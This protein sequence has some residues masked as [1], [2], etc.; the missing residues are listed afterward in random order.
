MRLRIRHATRYTYDRP[1]DYA[2]Q[3]VR[4]TPLNHMGQRVLS[5]R[6]VE[7]PGRRLPVTDDGYGNIVHMLTL[8]RQH[9]EATVLAEGEVETFD[10][11]GILK[12]SVERLPPLYYLRGTDMTEPDEALEALAEEVAAT[13]DPVKRLHRLMLATRARVAYQVGATTVTTT[14]VE[15]FA[16][17]SGVCQDH[18]HI[19]IACA[20]LLG[21]PA[22][23]VSGYLWEGPKEGPSEASHAWAEAHLGELGWVGFDPANGISPTEAYVRVAIG[24]D[25][26]EAAPIRG[27]RRGAAEESLAVS[28]GV[29]QVQA[30]Q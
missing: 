3:L 15:A 25:Y 9:R 1:I 6:V 11:N 20:R 18:A 24:L 29:E 28:V 4:L 10:T 23:Y 14:A 13:A 5:W 12:E 2:A 19:F 26:L 8:N 30:Q 7:D 21:H 22:R 16:R 17:G 27:V